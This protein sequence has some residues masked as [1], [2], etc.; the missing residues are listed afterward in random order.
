MTFRVLPE[1]TEDTHHEAEYYDERALGLGDEFLAALRAAY[2]AIAAPP[3]LFPKHE[4]ASSRRQ[5]R[6]AML[7]GFPIQVVYLVRRSEIIVFAVAHNSRKPG[8]WI[9]RKP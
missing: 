6:F 7:E 4:R 2:D 9:R 3:R 5:F 1:A 8:Y